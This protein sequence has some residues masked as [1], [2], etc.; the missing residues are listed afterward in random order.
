MLFRSS[1]TSSGMLPLKGE[2]AADL[3]DLILAVRTSVIFLAI[4]SVI[5]SEAEEG[6]EAAT[7]L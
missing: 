5:S 2:P 3:A 7:D 6:A 1:M 4:F